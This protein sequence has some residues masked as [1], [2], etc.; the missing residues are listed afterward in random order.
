MKRISMLLVVAMTFSLLLA[1]PAMAADNEEI[2]PYATAGNMGK[3]VSDVDGNT[4][5]VQGW[6]SISGTT[7][8][9]YTSYKV[10]GYADDSSE[11]K[12][13]VRKLVKSLGASGKGYLYSGTLGLSLSFSGDSSQEYEATA[14]KSATSANAIT[15]LV[16]SHTFSCNGVSTS[17]NSYYAK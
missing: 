2:T 15:S 13:A 7:G 4:Y 16:T 14:S 5:Y 17:G 9:I 8:Y 1:M 11:G 3:S 10:T 12:A 6:C